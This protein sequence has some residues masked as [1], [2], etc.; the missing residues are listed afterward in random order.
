MNP[1]IKLSARPIMVRY[2]GEDTE[3]ACDWY[4]A[5][6]AHVDRLTE[7][8]DASCPATGSDMSRPELWTGA[9]WNW[10]FGR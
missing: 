10:F 1:K 8:C 9:H 4:G 6:R 2:T 7:I 3:R 5:H